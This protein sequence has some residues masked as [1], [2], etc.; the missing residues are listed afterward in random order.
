MPK[1]W[2]TYAWKDNEDQD[3]D[4]VINELRGEGIE[5]IFD[6]AHLL[7]GQRLWEQIDK[8]IN[9]PTV[10]G[11]AIYTTQNSLASEPCQEEIAYA[12]DR[13]LRKK[14][15]NYPLV[16]IFPH[17]M[18]RSLV[19]SALATRLFVNLADPTWKTQIAD[20]LR[21][22]RTAPDLSS[23]KP[24][25][26]T[27]HSDKDGPILEIR[28]RSGQWPVSAVG[29]PENEASLLKGGMV[30]AAG[31]P[32]MSGIVMRGELNHP[33]LAGYFFQTSVNPAASI[34]VQFSHKPS[35]VWFGDTRYPLHHEVF[36]LPFNLSF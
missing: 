11:W 9:D 28:P 6:R 13:T 15:A 20:S 21:G 7:A 23:V 12:L 18:D 30:N 22:R 32:E 35:Q 26:L 19:P 17:A 4:H 24:Y 34:Y 14:G 16:G 31:Y 10:D 25:A 29:V 3:V 2:L 1:L 33:G 5:V 36:S 27:W 8:G